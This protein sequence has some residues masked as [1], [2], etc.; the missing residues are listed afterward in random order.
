MNLVAENPSFGNDYSDVRPTLMLYENVSHAIY[1]QPV[2]S[3]SKIDEPR[4][5][6][7]HEFNH[8]GLNEGFGG[9]SEAFKVL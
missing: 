9:F 3:V 1:Y 6:S 2:G 8:C 5:T 4:Q 7:Y